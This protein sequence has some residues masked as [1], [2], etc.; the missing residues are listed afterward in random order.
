MKPG[1]QMAPESAPVATDVWRALSAATGLR[2]E[3]SLN[4]GWREQPLLGRQTSCEL[5]RGREPLLG[6]QR[7]HPCLVRRLQAS[8]ASDVLALELESRP[9]GT[10]D[11][12]SRSW[13]PTWCGGRSVGATDRTRGDRQSTTLCP[14]EQ[15]DECVDKGTERLSDRADVCVRVADA[16]GQCVLLVGRRA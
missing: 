12:R 8:E 13:S 11:P 6:T 4:R 2:P 5:D 1:E 3:A 16:P 15:P 7:L 14:L 9:P 10:R